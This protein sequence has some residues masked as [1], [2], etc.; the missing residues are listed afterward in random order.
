M[1]IEIL[2]KLTLCLKLQPN[3]V[4]YRHK[5]IK[6]QWCFKKSF[7]KTHSQYIYIIKI[8]GKAD[9]PNTYNRFSSDI[10]FFI[11]GRNINTKP[12]VSV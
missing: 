11:Q 2:I 3:I 10:L 5:N 9:K 12:I 7:Y 6:I 8:S 1:D 4:K